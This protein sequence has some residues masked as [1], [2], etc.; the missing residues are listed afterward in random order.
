MEGVEGHHSP[1]N[2]P[3]LD[4]RQIIDCNSVR[5]NVKRVSE[6]SEFHQ[7]VARGGLEAIHWD[8]SAGPLVAWCCCIFLT[9]GAKV[10]SGT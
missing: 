3:L 9:A 10:A 4:V 8:S 6:R 2:R 5:Q 1:A 7:R